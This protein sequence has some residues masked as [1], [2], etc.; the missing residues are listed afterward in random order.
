MSIASQVQNGMNLHFVKD[1]KVIEGVQWRATKLVQGIGQ[2]HYD[3]RLK[4]LGLTRLES[5]RITI[6][7]IETYKIM[8]NVYSVPNIT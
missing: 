6:D 4:F 7:L 5:R 3:D 2:L 1:I 8:S